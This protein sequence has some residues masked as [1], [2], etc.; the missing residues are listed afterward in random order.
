MADPRF[1]LQDRKASF[2]APPASLRNT[3]SSQE[4]RRKKLDFFANLNLGRSDDEGG[5]VE[6]PVREGVA[7]FASMLPSPPTAFPVP[8]HDINAVSSNSP[9]IP[10]LVAEP[11]PAESADLPTSFGGKKKG[12]SKRKP[13]TLHHIQ[14]SSAQSPSQSKKPNKWA[15]KCMYAEL[16]EMTEDLEMVEFHGAGGT[17]NGDGIPQ[18]LETAWVAVTPV[19]IGKRC[20]AITHAPSGIAGAVPNTTLRSRVLGKS[21]MPPFPSSLPPHTVLDCIL[22]DDWKDNGILH[23]LDVLKWK[24]QDIG[25][26]ETPFRFW[27]RD[28]RMSELPVFPPPNAP[29]PSSTP[30]S[31]ASPQ[32]QYQYPTALIPIPYHLNLTLPHLSA[33]L[34]PL[35]RTIRHI[36]ITVPIS[37]LAEPQVESSTVTMELELS[38]GL[39]AVVELQ[40]KLAEVRPDGMLLYMAQ[41]SYEPGTSPLSTW[42]PIRTYAENRTSDGN[43]DGGISVPRNFSSALEGPLDI[44]ER[45]CLYAVDSSAG[46]WDKQ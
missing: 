11:I 28:T 16:L 10:D 13:K 27:W 20:L 42:V 38:E 45:L 44:F 39:N 14:K 37:M 4:V 29:A 46:D 24:G 25:D 26:C 15:D 6:E 19:P 21:L 35:T 30:H 23:V 32:Y 41:A 9:I 34:I 33:H 22:D 3:T 43:A 8:E 31:S 7:K 36:S 12:R 1:A 17:T 2:K 40:S 18:D 5:D